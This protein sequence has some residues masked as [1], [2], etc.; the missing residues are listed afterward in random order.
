MKEFL[1]RLFNKKKKD[2]EQSDNSLKKVIMN[3]QTI[4]LMS[5]LIYEILQANPNDQIKEIL[6][7]WIKAN[8]LHPE[9]VKTWTR[10]LKG[11]SKKDIKEI[12]HDNL[13]TFA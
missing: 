13:Q 2:D 9:S 12:V 6:M 1:K 4:A 7:S 8:D 11:L 10:S 3:D 5:I